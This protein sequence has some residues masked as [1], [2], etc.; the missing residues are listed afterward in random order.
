MPVQGL[1]SAVRTSRL[2]QVLGE[3]L[4]LQPSYGPVPAAAIPGVLGRHIATVVGRE[5][6]HR[7]PEQQREMVNHIL[8]LY[9]NPDDLIVALTSS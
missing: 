1:Y 6:A 7:T 9:G 4:E 2:E 8:E 3:R 5:L